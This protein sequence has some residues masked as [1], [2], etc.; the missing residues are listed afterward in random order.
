MPSPVGWYEVFAVTDAYEVILHGSDFG[1]GFPT[2]IV[3]FVYNITPF[4]QD[5][6]EP[7]GSPP[8]GQ[9]TINGAYS[10][11]TTWQRNP[12]G[13]GP[14]TGLT[15]THK[16]MA[17][18]ETEGPPDYTPRTPPYTWYA[19]WGYPIA[20]VDAVT[21]Q[22][23]ADD[24]TTPCTF[25]AFPIRA[26]IVGG[27]ERAP[28]ETL[29]FIAELLYADLPVDETPNPEA[30]HLYA[31]TDLALL[32]TPAVEGVS[33][34]TATLTWTDTADNELGFVV[35]RRELT[36]DGVWYE[37]YRPAADV[38]T[39]ADLFVLPGSAG[40]E[41]S[42][43]LEYRVYA[44]SGT[45]RS[46]NSNVVTL[47]LSGEGSEATTA[48]APVVTPGPAIA[49]TGPGPA[50][51]TT[52]VTITRGVLNGT[53]T[54]AWA[55]VSGPDVGNVSI[56]SPT[57]LDTDVVFAAYVPGVYVLELTVTTEAL[58]GPALVA[59][60]RLSLVIAPTIAPRVAGG[61]AQA[62]G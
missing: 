47:A 55:V 48:T 14:Y 28:G 41:T 23:K 44:Y 16:S 49:V 1:G 27:V 52:A 39:F 36:G 25:T 20:A 60:G 61:N 9:I 8:V 10:D 2:D 11:D 38:E 56:T 7:P 43:E 6:E 51:R 35:E 50:T 33:P 34:A 21:A 46:T 32:Y 19:H 4:V 30:D 24:G 18:Q 17:L 13:T 59:T 58:A 31:P 62:T 57:A 29:H 3:L 54:Y 15:A 22:L 53:L 42:P 26:T 12:P 37:M 5:P 45:L 40:F